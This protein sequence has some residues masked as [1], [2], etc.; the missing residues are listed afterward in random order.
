MSEETCILLQI[1]SIFTLA[2]PSAVAEHDCFVKLFCP[3]TA[4]SKLSGS[5]DWVADIMFHAKNGQSSSDWEDELED[6][7]DVLNIF[8]LLLVSLCRNPLK[9]QPRAR[10]T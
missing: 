3:L 6:K 1:I 5:L 9:G 10:T 4:L 7:E 8:T 2:R